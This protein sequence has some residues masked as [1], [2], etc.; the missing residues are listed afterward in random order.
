MNFGR[1]LAKIRQD[2]GH[3]QRWLAE[4]AGLSQSEISQLE[5]GVRSPTYKTIRKIAKA[6]NLPPACL[7]GDEL[8]GLSASERALL[9]GYRNLSEPARRKCERFVEDLCAGQEA[10]EE[11]ATPSGRRV[12]NSSGADRESAW[13]PD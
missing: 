11:S 3:N 12:V 2:L 13:Q 6:V 9:K 8:Q 5:S 7:L 1:R 4:A 10:E